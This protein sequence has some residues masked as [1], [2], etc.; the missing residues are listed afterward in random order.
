MRGL[1]TTGL[2][3]TAAVSFYSRY[4]VLIAHGAGLTHNVNQGLAFASLH[5]RFNTPLEFWVRGFFGLVGRVGLS[6]KTSVSPIPKPGENVTLTGGGYERDDFIF[7][8]K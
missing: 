8:A 6:S 4:R 7:V 5:A 3:F 1:V 2:F